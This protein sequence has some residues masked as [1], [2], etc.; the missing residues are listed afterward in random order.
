MTTKR[1]RGITGTDA[2]GDAE[3]DFKE[4]SPKDS[5]EDYLVTGGMNEDGLTW[6]RR[7]FQENGSGVRIIL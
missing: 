3:G 7:P 5:E 2:G 6:P 1:R 4:D